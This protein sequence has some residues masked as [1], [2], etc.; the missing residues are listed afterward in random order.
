M[1]KGVQQQ[2]KQKIYSRVD[3]DTSSSFRFFNESETPSK[4]GNID[5]PS[6]IDENSLF[7]CEKVNLYV[8][9]SNGAAVD[10]VFLGLLTQLILETFWQIKQ[11]TTTEIISYHTG[12]ILTYPMAVAAA[13]ASAYN[14]AAI[15]TGSFTMD[16]IWKIFGGQNINVT[17]QNPDGID[18]TGVTLICEL[19]GNIDRAQ[20]VEPQVGA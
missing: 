7:E 13:G 10:S 9:R 15:L 14:P 19:E 1:G 11:N 12:T 18:F 5:A 2:L 8:L 4:F 6:K 17:L 3:L 16:I 20:N